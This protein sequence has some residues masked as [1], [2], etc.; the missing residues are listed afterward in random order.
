M[1]S[2][3]W[4]TPPGTPHQT[5]AR[6]VV[7]EHGLARTR[8]TAQ[9]Q[10]LAFTSADGFS[11]VTQVQWKAGPLGGPST[12]FTIVDNNLV[13]GVGFSFATDKVFTL[14]GTKLNEG[15]FFTIFGQ[16]FS[17]SYAGGS[18]NND[19]VLTAVPEP[20]AFAAAFSGFALLLAFRRSRSL[21]R[22]KPRR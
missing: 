3:A 2:P 17:I 13:D 15:D 6:Q 11:G 7:Q 20:G 9:Y 8:V 10:G 12:S 5:P 22:Q 16:E 21:D 14:N 18:E 19:V 1:W 4:K